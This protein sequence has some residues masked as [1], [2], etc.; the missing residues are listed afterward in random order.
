M[1]PAL[2]SVLLLAAPLSAQ[3][4]LV[5]WYPLDEGSGTVANDA[6]GNGNF[7]ASSGTWLGTG[8]FGGSIQLGPTSS[9]LA[10]AG[11]SGSLAG[12]NA[13]TGNK[14][15]VSFWL[16]ANGESSG[17]SVFYAGNSN[18]ASASRFI[19]THMEW[20][21]GTTYWDVGWA[22]PGAGPR[23]SGDLGTVSDVLHH[24]VLT[25]NG[26]DGAMAVYKDG[27]VAISGTSGTIASLPW[28]GIQNFEIGA[29]SFSSFWPGGQIDDFAIFNTVLTPAEVNTAR[30]LGVA[31]LV[32]EPG[33]LSMGLLG[34][35]GLCA[36]RRR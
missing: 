4:T 5:A 13:T 27:A 25:Y 33:T 31:A 3:A 16:R 29:L 1:K 34:L 35:A 2:L 8:A 24:Y 10:R 32:P 18:T 36:R 14:I 23:I 19:N 21:D 9:L 6:S 17:S 7:M 15:S 30:T 22:T 28:A 20:S 26:D 11:G 12:L